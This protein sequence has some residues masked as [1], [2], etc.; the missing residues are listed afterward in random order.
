MSNFSFLPQTPS[1][2]IVYTDNCITELTIADI[3]TSPSRIPNFYP[4][5]FSVPDDA[6]SDKFSIDSFTVLTKLSSLQ[7]L[8]L[9]TLRLWGPLL[10]KI[11]CFR[12]LELLNL[13]ANFLVGE[14]PQ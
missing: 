9:V 2:T 12:S 3:W 6:L 5:N 11:N 13:S 10:P 1:P 7:K 4:S 14:V 8:S